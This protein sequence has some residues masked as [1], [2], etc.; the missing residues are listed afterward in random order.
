MGMRVAVGAAAGLGVGV[1]VAVAVG[2]SVGV[3]V[4]VSAGVCV[5]VGAGVGSAVGDGVGV[6]VLT[7]FATGDGAVSGSAHALRSN[8]A[9]ARAQRKTGSLTMVYPRFPPED[10]RFMAT[11]PA[12]PSQAH[13]VNLPRYANEYT[14]RT[15]P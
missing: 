14:S 6:S 4:G 9:A 8:A 5:G 12:C 7:A 2:V 15:H 3:A 13:S 10:R 1:G 11:R